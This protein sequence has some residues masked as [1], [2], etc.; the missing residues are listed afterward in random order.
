MATLEK[1]RQQK[2]WLAI[3]IGGALLAFIIEVGVEAI[4]RSAGKSVAAKVGKEKIDI[5]EFSRRVEQDA[6]RDQQN[7]Q[8]YDAAQRQQK[9]LDE[10]IGEKLLGQEYDKL[11]IYV[12]DDEI[13]ELMIGKNPTPAVQQFAQQ[14]GA[15]SP[16][17]LFDFISNPGKQ[18]VSEA[19]VAE[20]RNEWNRVQNDV[21]KQYKL[22]KLQ[23]LIAG[24][25]QANDLE[26]AQMS[27]EE[28]L[29]NVTLFAK[30]DLSTLPDDQFPVSDEE[31]KAEWEKH[32]AMFKNDEENRAIHYIAVDIVP[33]AEDIAA[34]N[35]IANAAYVALQ[36]GRGIDSVRLLGTVQ[37][38]TAKVIKSDMPASVRDLFAGA[39][40]GAVHRDS[41]VN[42]HHVMYKLI[43]KQT[44][45]DSVEVAFVV[46]NG[47]RKTQQSVIEQLNSGKTI[48]EVKKAFPQKLEVT[49]KSWQRVYQLPDSMKAKIGNATPGVYFAYVA[50]D[51][52]AQLVKVT[53]K[54]APKTFY[55]VATVSYDA[56]ASTKTSE[57]LRDKFQQFLNK[58]NTVKAFEENA[59][60]EGY[61]AVEAVITPNTP[62]LGGNQYGYGGIKDSRKA[63][64]WAFDNKKGDVSPIFSDNNNVLIA[65]AVDDIYEEGYL[66]YTVPQVK[67]MLTIR[68]RNAK[69]G[70]ALIKKLQGKANSVE[71]YA[72]LMNAKTDTV[73][74]MF[75]LNGNHKLGQDY[76]IMARMAVAKPGQLM[77]PW[78]GKN[79]VF[80]YQVLR[81]EKSERKPTKEE[82]DKRYAQNRGAQIFANPNAITEILSKVNKVKKSI[83]D[84]Y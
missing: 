37:I 69:K 41:T 63:I 73:D 42:N 1:I 18:G 83:I 38:D 79:A 9:V 36:K 30:Q 22:Y 82:L 60:K 28:S 26:R 27:E 32:K 52:A 84:F 16:A 21:V 7:Q 78:K 33:N 48:D 13:S 23:N 75:A 19:S 74:A 66:P 29:T 53:D 55:T 44:S 62:Q 47:D 77:G 76:G 71:A 11:G 10:M 4:G 49:D 12:T 20:L 45:L 57:D 15:K 17:E 65:V 31:I 14:A 51:K 3:V 80:V 46:V 40:I 64:K 6:A 43:N 72:Q 56:Y 54:K 2:M 67:E 68:V 35:K 8:Q 59:A 5:M 70:E 50:H 34:A 58:N 61:N 81:Q 25:M 24:C 39:E